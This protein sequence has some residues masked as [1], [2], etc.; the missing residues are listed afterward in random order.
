MKNELEVL[1]LTPSEQG[2]IDPTGE[3]R[4]VIKRFVGNS[5][6]TPKHPMFAKYS[7]QEWKERYLQLRSRLRLD[8]RYIAWDDAHIIK[9]GAQGGAFDITEVEE[10]YRRQ[11]M[12]AQR[13]P[14]FKQVLIGR[15]ILIRAIRTAIEKYGYPD[16]ST[17]HLSILSTG[18]G[19]PTMQKKGT[20][21]AE[22]VGCSPYR[23]AAPDLPGQRRQ[24]NK[25][26]VINQDATSNVRYIERIMG[27]CRNWLRKYLPQYFGSWLKPSSYVKPAIYKALQHGKWFCET[28]FTGCDEHTTWEEIYSVVLPIYENLLCDAAEY[29]QLACFM[30]ELFDQPI[31]LGD[32]M[33]TGTH[34]LLSGQVITNDVETVY[35]VCL[36][37]GAQAECHLLGEL[38]LSNGDDTDASAPTEL[39]AMKYRDAVVSE[40]TLNGHEFNLE[41]CHV[42]RC[43]TTY[44]RT[45]YAPGIG[46]V[47]YNEEGDPYLQG[48]YPGILTLNSV[49]NPE[50]KV[51][52]LATFVRASLQKLDGLDGN[53]SAEPVIAFC[54]R[55]SQPQR[56]V[57]RDEVETAFTYDWWSR[58]Y[59]ES[60]NL[61]ASY[62]AQVLQRINLISKW[63]S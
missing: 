30:E 49:I 29:N 52:D 2:A 63:I 33:L 9:Y 12:L 6:F 21:Y 25:N 34:T 54:V 15:G 48:A 56:C 46:R 50:Y 51:S 43:E 40:G 11:Y 62:S 27:A 20:F 10:Q 61:Q 14:Q 3:G 37:L 4:A 55:N 36:E 17:Y 59:G 45:L 57:R 19:L 35:D 41:K 24:R 60:W 39:L 42:R 13:N 18:G 44:L 16:S 31:F 32:R 5:T 53:P 1:Y 58:V 26:R 28:D 23:H 47:R 22:A 38:T 8:A 7:R